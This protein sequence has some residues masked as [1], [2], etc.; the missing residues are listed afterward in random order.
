MLHYVERDE[1]LQGS[2][3]HLT[4]KGNKDQRG[5]KDQR[6]ALETQTVPNASGKGEG[7][8]NHVSYL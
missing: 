7:R 1:K 2:S 6:S 5:I 8:G 3:R 4:E